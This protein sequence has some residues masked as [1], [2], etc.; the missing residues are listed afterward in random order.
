MGAGSL[1]GERGHLHGLGRCPVARQTLGPLVQA[2]VEREAQVLA[3]QIDAGDG[4]PLRPRLCAFYRE[5]GHQLFV[6]L[7]ERHEAEEAAYVV[8]GQHPG[9]HLRR[10]L[11]EL[12]LAGAVLRPVGLL[13]VAERRAVVLEA[14]GQEHQDGHHADEQPPEELAREEAGLRRGRAAW[15]LTRPRKKPDKQVR[16]LGLG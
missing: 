15:T 5:P 1:G 2:A 6:L 13:A 7:A 16:G 14:L 11:E 9:V 4:V 3:V 10:A 12:V 8:G